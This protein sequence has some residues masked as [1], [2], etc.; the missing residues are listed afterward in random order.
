MVQNVPVTVTNASGV[1]QQLSARY[2][3]VSM[4]MLLTAMEIVLVIIFVCFTS[5]IFNIECLKYP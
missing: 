1:A 3:D 4:A 5:C 2:T